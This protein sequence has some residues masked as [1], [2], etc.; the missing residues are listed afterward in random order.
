MTRGSCLCGEIQFEADEIEGLG[1]CHCSMCR[2]SHGAAFATYAE[3]AT[4]GL[5]FLKGADRLTR[6]QSSP[7]ITRSFCPT[8]G[9]NLLFAFEGAPD[10]IW[11]AA[12]CFDDDPGVRPRKHIF[13]AS[14][15][16][17]YEISDSLPQHAEYGGEV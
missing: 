3:V 8:C 12:G 2:K 6:Y 7:P 11:V 4:S 5:R 1:N 14:K 9:A 16:P 15:A 10:R 17:W 13:V